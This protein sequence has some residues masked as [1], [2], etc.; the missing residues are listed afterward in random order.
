MKKSGDK[1]LQHA[2]FELNIRV[3]SSEPHENP[4]RLLEDP[5]VYKQT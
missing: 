2:F 5:V 3:G 4:I 1:N